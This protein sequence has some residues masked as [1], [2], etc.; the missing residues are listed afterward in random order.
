MKTELLTRLTSEPVR[1]PLEPFWSPV[2]IRLATAGD[3]GP[4]ERLAQLDSA[5]LPVGGIM[6]GELHGRPVVAVSLTDG[7]VIADPFV[8]TAEIAELVGLRA[9][10]VGPLAGLERSPRER[11]QSK[12]SR[13]AT[14]RAAPQMGSVLPMYRRLSQLIL[15]TA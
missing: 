5:A 7:T 2:V 3:R 8:S 12:A 10:Q 11:R 14:K 9:R 13:A 6:M 1:D 15:R 4:L